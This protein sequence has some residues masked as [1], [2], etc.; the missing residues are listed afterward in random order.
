MDGVWARQVRTRVELLQRLDGELQVFGAS[1]HEWQWAP[2]LTRE[3][4][5]SFEHR[6]GVRLPDDLRGFLLELG[7]AGAGPYYGLAP[8]P[9]D[10]E[11]AKLREAFVGDAALD[12]E[13]V[14]KD[15]SRMGG[16]LVLAE[17]GCGYKSL[18]A[19]N[20]P[21]EGQVFSDSREASGGVVLEAT[22]FRAW[23]DDWLDRALVEWAQRA[24]PELATSDVRPPEAEEALELVAPLLEAAAAPNAPR[25][26]HEELYT[27]SESIHVS[28]LLHLRI[29]QRRFD[30]ARALVERLRGVPEADGEANGLLAQARIFGAEGLPEKRL[31]AANDGLATPSLWSSTRTSL[32]REKERALR[33]LDRHDELVATVLERARHT[34]ERYAYFDAACVQLEGNDVEAAAATLMLA[35]GEEGDL[36]TRAQRAIELAEELFDV[37]D[38]SEEKDLRAYLGR[39]AGAS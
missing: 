7:S 8:L 33:S 25:T 16:A 20:G 38:P 14:R 17:H 27:T 36:P 32:L 19:L 26:P 6:A 18:L 12:D 15:P 35:A 1:T 23:Y 4:L 39:V 11:A 37:L 31:A 3:T 13:S 34:G 5:D 29:V 22:S 21:R 28:A 24:L 2:P 9:D 30:E 10:L